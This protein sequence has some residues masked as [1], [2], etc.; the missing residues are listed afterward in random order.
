[1]TATR[2]NSPE[3]TRT[4][5]GRRPLACVILAGGLG[6]RMKSALPKVLHTVC[7]KPMISYPLLAALGL[8]PQKII[9]VTGV[10]SHADITR[11]LSSYGENRKSQK[12]QKIEMSFALQKN[13]LGTGHALLTAM[14]KL[15][16]FHGSVVVLNGDFPLI[17]PGTVRK[18]LGLHKRHG[19]SVTLG[20]FIAE[21]PGPYG[22]IVRDAA[23]LPER[24]VEKTDLTPSEE[25][26][27]EVNSGLYVFEPEA[28]ALLGN[29][30]KNRSKKEYYLT[31][32]LALARLAGLKTGAYPIAPEQEF[33]GVNNYGELHLAETVMR[34]RIVSGFSESGVR[35]LAPDTVFM[36]ADVSCAPGAMI[37]PN[38]HLQGRTSIGKGCIIYPNVRI[39]DSVIREGALVLDSSV[40][41]SS[42]VGK[43]AQVGPFAH[44]R[45]GSSIEHSAKIGNF[46]EIKNSTIGEGTK[47][48]HLSY[49]GDSSVGSSV[50][51]G[52]GTITCNYD[53]VN[54]HRTVIEDGVFIGS[55]SQLVAPVTV[56]QGSFVAAGSTITRD[57]PE[58]SLA[59]SR[60]QQNNVAGWS[61]KKRRVK[62]VADIKKKTAARTH[63]AVDGH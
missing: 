46:V 3:R 52:A 38:V 13:P 6:T 4:S 20:S 44:L 55:D 23:G 37:Y 62:T 53:G 40:I 24:I 59:I 33:A 60:A 10:S 14:E 22:R 32:I 50:N 36:D 35:F 48:M 47:A 21:D 58:D 54:K 18:L 9:I 25:H 56:K 19:N 8:R 39:I 26:I 16:G 30:E 15:K 28:V 45:P 29:I 5:A 49:I 7:G 2:K 63:A 34:R 17:T 42:D 12:I 1:M 57:V 43:N 61:K 27:M 31:D 11:A 51:I 41:E